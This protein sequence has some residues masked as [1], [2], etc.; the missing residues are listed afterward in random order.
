VSKKRKNTP[1]PKPEDP[2]GTELPSGRGEMILYQTEDGQ[3][4]VE[5]R[6][7]N[8][9]MWLT[10]Q[11]MAELFGKS[12]KTISEHIRNIFTEGELDEKVV[13]RNFR[14]TTRHGAMEG[15]T[16]SREV[17]FYNLD[18]II[19]VGY[20]VRSQIGTQFR[21]WATRLL[22]EYI[23]KG[24]VMDDERL[25]NPPSPESGIPDYFDEI[26]ERIRDIRASEKRMYLRVREIFKLAADYE[27][28]ATETTTF[29]QIIQNKLHFA[30][31][32]LTAAELIETR[33]DHLLPNMG[34]TTWK[35]NEVRKADVT[36]AKNYLKEDEIDGL[37]RI[38][39]MWL[40]FAEDQ[41]RRRKQIFMKDWQKKLDDFLVLNERD[42]LTNAGEISMDNA[43]DKAK[44]EYS[45]FEIRR[46]HFKEKIGNEDA[47]KDLED[48]AKRLSDS[49]QK[50][51]DD[52]SEQK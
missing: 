23:V 8:E 13:V 39:V 19:S 52:G 32:G 4:R 11:H 40:D 37:N 27:P 3:T 48:A 36:V 45:Q 9:T 21:I 7:E 34:L 18:A 38:V 50:N 25:K 17:Q 43:Q 16:Q 26:L 12:K 46:R 49:S 29:F 47:I 6:L 51:V 41:A 15:K 10:Q 20:R 44:K 31:T 33:A 5:C 14:T 42:V 28:S 22:K 35:S 2:E 30:A 1:S 24:F